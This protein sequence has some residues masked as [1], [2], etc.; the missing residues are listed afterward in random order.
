MARPKSK[1]RKR[2]KTTGRP[3]IDLSRP[4]L[5]VAEVEKRLLRACKTLRA[6]PDPT[7][8]FQWLKASW[9][10]VVRSTEDAY[11][12]TDA[13]MPKF[14]PTTHDVTDYLV[15]LSWVRPVNWKEFRLVWWRSFDLSFG[16]MAVR[17]NKTD[18]TA[19]RWYRDVIL[20]AWHEANAEN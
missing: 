19:R 8:R 5:M 7:R 10:E 12:Y 14:H 15:A 11:G 9:P 2:D 16:Q 13:A 4:V 17:L 1:D 18:E 20:R 6:L 3:F